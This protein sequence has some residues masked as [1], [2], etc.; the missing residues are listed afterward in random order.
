M[1]QNHSKS[2]AFLLCL[3]GFLGF[4][5][6]HRL[7]TGKIGTG[8]IWFLTAGWAGVGTVIDLILIGTGAYRDKYGRTLV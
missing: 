8:I 1:P 7:Y 3:L 2:T 6:I 4:A 5:G